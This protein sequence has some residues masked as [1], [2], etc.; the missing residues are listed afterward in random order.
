V[1]EPRGEIE[2]AEVCRLAAAD[3]R[4]AVVDRA[5]AIICGEG[6]VVQR[7]EIQTK[8]KS[9]VFL[10]DAEDGRVKGG[11]CRL[12]DAVLEPRRDVVM[13]DRDVRRRDRE[14]FAIGRFLRGRVNLVFHESAMTQV[15]FITRND[16]LKVEEQAAQRDLLRGSERCATASS[17]AAYRRRQRA[18][19]TRGG[20]GGRADAGGR[21]PTSA[22]A[23]TA[24]RGMTMG[25]V[26]VLTR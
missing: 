23:R 22:T 10:R 20:G 19:A 18:M 17:I 8:A 4:E 11:F 16:V 26:D 1:I 13:N 24:A 14:L 25:S 21:T 12:N 3:L 6:N 7:A 5:N 2:R 15:E 9:A